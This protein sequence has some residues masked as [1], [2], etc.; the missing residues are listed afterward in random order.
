MQQRQLRLGDILDDYCPRERRVTNHAVVA[1]VG[2]DVKQT[3]CTTCD[4]EHEYKHAKVPRQRRKA[5][6]PAALYAQV[7][8]NG[9]KRVAHELTAADAELPAHEPSMDPEQMISNNGDGPHDEHP[10]SVES[11]RPTDTPGD[12]EQ[13]ADREPEEDGPVHR[14]LIRA[15]LPRPEGQQPPPRPIPEFTIRQPGGRPGRFRPRH[16]RG[17]PQGQHFQG[18]NRGNGSFSGGPPR[19][20]RPGGGGGARP[21][22]SMPSRMGRRH[23]PGR[24]RSK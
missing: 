5:D 19:G 9:P 13:V 8:A 15:S 17:G 2:A 1:M 22:G 20:M 3:R 12:V 16:Q 10:E 6:T 23:G 4:T 11:D 14:P 18:G 7:A 24:K 21:Q